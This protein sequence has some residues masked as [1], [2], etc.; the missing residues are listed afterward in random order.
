MPTE[1]PSGNRTKA[2]KE[3]DFID[4][5]RLRKEG[6]TWVEVHDWIAQ[7]RDYTINHYGLCR[8]Y[9]SECKKAGIEGLDQT[10]QSEVF[11]QIIDSINDAQLK[12]INAWAKSC[13]DVVKTKA[14]YVVKKGIKL[15]ISEAVEIMG[16]AGNPKFLTLFLQCEDKRA[17][18]Y[19]LGRKK[20][21]PNFDFNFFMENYQIDD[22]FGT[23]RDEPILSEDH[24]DSDFEK[25]GY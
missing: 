24:V 1:L 5:T 2:Q 16:S 14:E 7:N 6:K 15:K 13:E 8:W 19:D 9:K 20:D 17:K 4:I 3:Q 23:F 10:A 25:K 12:A 22:D 18:L 11:E 21:G